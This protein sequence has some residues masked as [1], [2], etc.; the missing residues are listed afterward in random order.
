MIVIR[1]ATEKDFGVIREIAHRTWPK[2]FGS[3]L[4]KEQIDYMLAMMYS[5]DALMEQTTHKNHVFFLAHEENECVGYASYQIDYHGLP[6]TKVHK[7]YILPEVQGKGVGRLLLE[8]IEKVAHE[9]GNTAISL[10]VN[11][12]NPSVKFYEKVGF[13]KKGEENISIGNGFL[14]EDFIMEKDILEKQRQK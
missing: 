12:D 8:A 3:I 4:S 11:R 6:K 1:K 5:T 10:N 7:I 9:N 2:T 13:V 14:M